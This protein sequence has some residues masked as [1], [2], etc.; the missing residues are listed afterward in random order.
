MTPAA[1]PRLRGSGSP[2]SAP[3]VRPRCRHRRQPR[4][5]SFV[6]QSDSETPTSWAGLFQIDGGVE[7]ADQDRPL[8]RGEI[9]GRAPRPLSDRNEL[10]VVMG[11]AGTP[12]N[13]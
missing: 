6:D 1:Q 2:S 13:A 11:P 9:L 3:R 12:A 4:E 5:C 8:D 7:I 10:I